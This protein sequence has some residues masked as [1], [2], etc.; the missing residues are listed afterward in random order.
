MAPSVFTN[1]IEPNFS[2][3]HSTYR[4]HRNVR[5]W[6]TGSTNSQTTNLKTESFPSKPATQRT[7]RRSA[8]AWMPRGFSGVGS[9]V[10]SSFG[11][12]GFPADRQSYFFFFVVEIS[13]VSVCANGTFEV[14]H[15]LPSSRGC[16]AF[17]LINSMKKRKCLQPV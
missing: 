8:E 6:K 2:P 10:G 7:R 1:G 14:V 13:C 11:N 5:I 17:S 12:P 3:F 16:C 4:S 15:E 9:S